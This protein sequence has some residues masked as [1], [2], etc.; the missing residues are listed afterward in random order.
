MGHP[1]I[2]KKIM[3]HPVLSIKGLTAV[4]RL[5]DDNQSFNKKLLI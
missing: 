4:I 2:N 3:G 1:V 5:V